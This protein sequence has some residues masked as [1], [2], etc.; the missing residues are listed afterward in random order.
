M[1]SLCGI[2]I[3]RRTGR[4]SPRVFVPP[5]SSLINVCRFGNVSL[6]S[7]TA[8]CFL[9]QGQSHSA[10]TEGTASARASMISASV[11]SSTLF[12]DSWKR[13]AFINL[14]LL[15][16]DG[17]ALENAVEK[18]TRFGQDSR[19]RRTAQVCSSVHICTPSRAISSRVVDSPSSLE[20]ARPL[21]A[22]AIAKACFPFLIM[23]Y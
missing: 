9:L 5:L 10:C 16:T 17:S 12:S 18:Q 11:F 4:V 8:V 19:I 2:L 20:P 14:A 13:S 1:F 7:T 15:E 21:S 23:M 6:R 3:V 22:S